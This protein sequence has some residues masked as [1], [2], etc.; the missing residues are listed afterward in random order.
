MAK[1][2]FCHPFI[3]FFSG[4]WATLAFLFS[5]KNLTKAQFLWH[6]WRQ[7]SSVSVVSLEVVSGETFFSLVASFLKPFSSSHLSCLTLC[8]SHLSSPRLSSALL[9]FFVLSPC[10][11]LCTLISSPLCSGSIW[12][13]VRQPLRSSVQCRRWRAGNFVLKDGTW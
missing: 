11:L 4:M 13:S 5:Q 12:G 9:I 1:N 3:H 2:T 8:T 10:P 7:E 6:C